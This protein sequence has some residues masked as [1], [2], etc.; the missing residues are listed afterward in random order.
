MPQASATRARKR[1]FVGRDEELETLRAALDDAAAERGGLLLVTGEPGIGKTRLMQEA[2]A[3]A[4]D[5][6][7]RVAM[8]RCWEEGGAP[9]YWPWAQVVRA[10]G[11]ELSQVGAPRSAGVGVDPESARFLMFDAVT[12]F[13]VEV[14]RE[15]ELLIVLDD[16]HAADAPSLL[17]LRFLAP[18][19]A[20]ERILVLGSYRELESRR[21]ELAGHFAELARVA[22][23]KPLAGLGVDAVEAY[24]TALHGHA[25]TR[26][27]ATRLQ[28]MTG[29]NPFFLTQIAELG[30]AAV[31]GE[32]RALI[33]R[34]VDGLSEDARAALSMA[35]VCGREFDLRVLEPLSDVTLGR[36]LDVLAEAVEAGVVWPA[37]AP[38][39]YTFAHDL[40]R[41]TLYDDLS[42]SR[43]A[44]LHLD[45]GHV[46]EEVHRGDLDPHLSEIAHHLAHAAPLGDR[47]AGR[48]DARARRRAGMHAAGLR[49]GDPALRPRA[50][51]GS[52]APLRAAAAA[53]RRPV[54][55]RRRAG[56]PPE[57]RDGDRSRAPARRR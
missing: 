49:G 43:R 10:A 9:A 28:A 50:G 57:L 3:S 15:R 5:R 47:A 54:A 14:S 13:L 6:G 46:L 35:A 8:G 44:E 7:W 38:G 2:A 23:R 29:G 30:D 20:Q 36:L 26:E 55:G 40:V 1:P 27:L 39:R 22:Q 52:R 11:G 48:R 34:R 41:E 37:P 31:P 33:R 53:R 51:A 56:R 4:L 24:L 42:P 12:R 19:I 16:L 17:L 18:A 25:A 45:I 21:G 32:V